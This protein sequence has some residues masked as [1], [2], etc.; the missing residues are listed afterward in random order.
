[1]RVGRPWGPRPHLM[2][3]LRMSPRWPGGRETLLGVD[4]RVSPVGALGE[5]E[6][7]GESCSK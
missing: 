2:P 5:S 4:L 7:P 6:G 3:R 1:M